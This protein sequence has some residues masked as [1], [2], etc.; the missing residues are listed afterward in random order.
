M[1]I[2][3]GRVGVNRSDVDEL[4]HVTSGGMTP[5]EREKLE[6]SL[7]TPVVVPTEKEIVGVG[8]SNEQIMFKIGDGLSVDGETSPFTLK[9]LGGA[10]ITPIWTNPS[11]TNTP[12][13]YVNIPDLELGY[14]YLCTFREVNNASA[15]A[16][17]GILIA[18]TG[19][20]NANATVVALGGASDSSTIYARKIEIDARPG[21]KNVN[22]NTARSFTVNNE[23]TVTVENTTFALTPYQIF[24][25]WRVN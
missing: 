22:F 16:G 9:S 15:K 25:L 10:N 3:A 2:K 20:G 1:A 24:K 19:T 13:G 6:K 7:V 11:D 4:G 12:S 18:C 23:G 5:E 14:V 21:F 17:I 8:T